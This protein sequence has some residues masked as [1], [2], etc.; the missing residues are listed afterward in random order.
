MANRARETKRTA[1]REETARTDKTLNLR[2]SQLVA[3]PRTASTRIA[4]IEATGMITGHGQRPAQAGQAD[5]QAH[6]G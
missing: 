6:P 2:Y 5:W 3:C 4:S 1:D